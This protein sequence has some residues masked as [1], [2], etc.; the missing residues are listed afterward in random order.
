MYDD[1]NIASL[2]TLQRLRYVALKNLSDLENR[3]GRTA[4]CLD[5]LVEAVGL[6]DEDPMM[7]FKLGC[8]ARSLDR[9]GLARVAL[10]TSLA[11]QPLHWLTMIQLTE[12]LYLL[13]DYDEAEAL[14]KNVGFKM[15]ANWP[16]GH[17]ILK[18]IDAENSKNGKYDELYV[19]LPP[20]A[21]E[22]LSPRA[23]LQMQQLNRISNKRKTRPE[24]D[25]IDLTQSIVDKLVE[26]RAKRHKQM[27]SY[28]GLSPALGPLRS[29]L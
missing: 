14:I 5:H 10:V 18:R 15:D 22:M 1:P 21:P 9:L 11:R 13:G 25:E 12:V 8:A 17:A 4:E 27:G 3:S 16:L 7:W 19:P 26:S 23:K 28:S 2:P 20:K 29:S 24:S 6:F